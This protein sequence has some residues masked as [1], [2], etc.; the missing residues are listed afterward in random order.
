MRQGCIVISDIKCD[1]CGRILK[2]P[3]RYLRMSEEDIVE[4]EVEKMLHYCVDCCLEKG[5]A[6]YKKAEKGVQILTFFT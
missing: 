5:Y 4:T 1:G 3:D 6:Q 2:H